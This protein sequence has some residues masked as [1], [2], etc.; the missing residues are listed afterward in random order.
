MDAA[1]KVSTNF[2][3]G[4]GDA[5]RTIAILS[6]P[7]FCAYHSLGSIRLHHENAAAVLE[8]KPPWPN[9]QGQEGTVNRSE[10]MKV[11]WAFQ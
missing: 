7:D 10:S 6:T 1:P 2:A 11:T 3:D 5:G 9:W 8:D 4:P